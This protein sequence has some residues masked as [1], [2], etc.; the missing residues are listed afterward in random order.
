MLI[1]ISQKQEK[2]NWFKF[3]EI[4]VLMQVN[5]WDELSFAILQ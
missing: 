2:I 1:I 4:N 3:S 5:D